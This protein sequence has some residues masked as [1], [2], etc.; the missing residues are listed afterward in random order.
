M[1]FRWEGED[2]ITDNKETFKEETNASGRAMRGRPTIKFHGRMAVEMKWL[3]YSTIHARWETTGHL[4]PKFPAGANSF[5]NGRVIRAVL[6]KET[7]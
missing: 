7:I 1:T 2:L 5:K 6:L 4:T 3:I